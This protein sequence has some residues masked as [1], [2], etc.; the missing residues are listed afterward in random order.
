MLVKSELGELVEI[1]R[2]RKVHIV[3]WEPGVV[4]ST[5][6]FFFHGSMATLNQFAKLFPVF[7]EMNLRIVAYD[8]LG[9][10]S[11]TKPVDSLFDD[12][13]YLM[14]E[15]V[16]DA[17]EVFTKYA[18][19]KNFLVGHSFG[20]T[21]VARIIDCY[22]NLKNYPTT[23]NGVILLGTTDKLPSRGPSIF[24][25]P[26]F[27]LRI[28]HPILSSRFAGKALSPKCD[29]ETRNEISSQSGKNEM[30]VV[31]SF[32][33]NFQWANESIWTSLASSKIP[34]L[35]CQGEDDA[36]T[37]PEGA[38]RLFETYFQSS[39]QNKYITIPASGHQLMQETPMAVAAAIKNFVTSLEK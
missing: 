37:K 13:Y 3:I 30:H 7:K 6:I 14:E 5:T 1:R 15:L 11:S 21:V 39:T 25:L 23:I 19:E 35:I 28:I 36:I 2:D 4:T 29:P 17:I 38:L 16:L 27:L 34:V 8:A 9:C 26:V 24:A 32:Y 22:H 10:G 20:T 31:K 33:R 12:S 18:S